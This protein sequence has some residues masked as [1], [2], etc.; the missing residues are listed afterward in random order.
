LVNLDVVSS[1]S[2]ATVSVTFDGMTTSGLT[3]TGP[4]DLGS[5]WYRHHIQFTWTDAVDGENVGPDLGGRSDYYWVYMNFGSP[6][7]GTASCGVFWDVTA[8]T[9]ATFSLP[10]TT[11]SPAVT[12]D[13]SGS[14]GSDNSDGTLQPPNENG[15]S[16]YVVKQGGNE[17]ATVPY[18]TFQFVDDNGGA[19]YAHNQVLSYTLETVDKAGNVASSPAVGTTI[20]L[21]IADPGEW[22]ARWNRDLDGPS[23]TENP[24]AA[25][26]DTTLYWNAGTGGTF[27]YRILWSTSAAGAYTQIY[28]GLTGTSQV[29]DWALISGVANDTYWFKL[30]TVEGGNM[31]DSAPMAVVYDRIAPLAATI[32]W[33]YGTVYAPEYRQVPIDITGSGKST[34]SGWTSDDDPTN[35]GSGVWRYLV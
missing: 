14:K 5:G 2:T 19:G 29:L 6:V 30:R 23:G 9:A 22:L 8:P 10:G 24:V 32:S 4:V 7:Q 17:V 16:H 12:I 28:T 34:D 3:V 21:L 20:S 18:G 13:W 1:W 15:I 27:T 31:V 25:W 35:T 33:N 26:D 11:T